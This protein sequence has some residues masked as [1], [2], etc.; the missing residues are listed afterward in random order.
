VDG[1]DELLDR[2]ANRLADR[3]FE[4]LADRVFERLTPHLKAMSGRPEGLISAREVARMTG[5]SRRRVYDL[6]AV[7]LGLR[8][9]RPGLAKYSLVSSATDRVSFSPSRL[10]QRHPGIS[11]SFRTDR[12]LRD[13]SPYLA[14]AAIHLRSASAAPAVHLRSRAPRSREQSNPGVWGDGPKALALSRV[15]DVGERRA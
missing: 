14:R 1:E 9:H 8:N 10:P 12:H 6:G 7:P 4:R 3:V 15:V 5:R 11:R 2:L 13:A